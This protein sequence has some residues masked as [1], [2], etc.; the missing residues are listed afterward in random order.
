M[1]VW[2]TLLP[3]SVVSLRKIFD[4]RIARLQHGTK[5]YECPFTVHAYAQRKLILEEGE[6]KLR[7]DI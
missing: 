1:S 3:R 6:I 7:N 4:V 5:L 2:S